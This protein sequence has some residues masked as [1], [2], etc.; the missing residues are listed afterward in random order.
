MDDLEQKIGQILGDPDSMAQIMSIAKS[1]GVMQPEQ[2]AQPE[3]GSMS[4]SLF[5]LEELGPIM[6]IVR[7]AGN[8]EQ[9]EAALLNALKPYCS[10]ER[11][12]RI[13]RA[14]RIARLSQL[15][16]AALRSFDKRE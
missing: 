9:R 4:D 13:D 10:A 1:L 12:Q 11:Q 15:A 6:E 7:R 3:A 2:S 8:T 16:G 14:V 5:S